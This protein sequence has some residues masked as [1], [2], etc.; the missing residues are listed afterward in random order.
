MR[1][2]RQEWR[3]TRRAPDNYSE[4]GG[5]SETLNTNVVIG[6]IDRE[7]PLTLDW[8]ITGLQQL[9]LCISSRT[10]AINVETR[11]IW[12]RAKRFYW[13]IIKSSFRFECVGL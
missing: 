3:L 12:K 2:G 5:A 1:G 8:G 9:G 7:L 6:L 4:I 13:M 10:E 11:I